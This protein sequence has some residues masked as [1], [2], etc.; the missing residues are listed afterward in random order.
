MNVPRDLQRLVGK[1]ELRYS[2]KT[3]YLGIAKQKSRYL[4]GQVQFIFKVLRKGDI[5]A[6]LSDDQIK[7]LVNGYIKHSL[8][9]IN[10]LFNDDPGNEIPPFTNEPEF[11]SYLNELNGIR[12]DLIANL[13]MGNW[14]MLEDTISDFLKK[15]G[16][17]DVDKGSGE[18]RRLC[19]GIHQA[20]I[21]LLPIQRRHMANDF[22]YKD[23][24]PEIF[25]EVFPK[26]PKESEP[27]PTPDPPEKKPS[28]LLETIIDEYS[29]E[30]ESAGNWSERTIIEYRSIFKLIFDSKVFTF[31]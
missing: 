28:K 19:A 5:M 15:Q 6:N 25:P 30:N 26:L 24:L 29:K 14:G 1:K 8:E 3:G 23:E 18:Y 27:I 2:L 31:V 4:A 17:K 10:N 16:I 20:E 11:Y 12:Q 9:R 22:S 7:E 13:N 21:K